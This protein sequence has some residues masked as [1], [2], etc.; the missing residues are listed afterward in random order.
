[1]NK[2]FIAYDSLDSLIGQVGELQLDIRRLAELQNGK[3]PRNRLL[4]R[5]ETAS[6]LRISLSTLHRIVKSGYLP[7]FKVGRRTLFKEADVQA[8]LIKINQYDGNI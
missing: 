2:T 4:T 3:P 8:C 6:M 5:T 7:S 1:M